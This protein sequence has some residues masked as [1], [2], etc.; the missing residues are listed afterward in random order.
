MEWVATK[1]KVRGE[2]RKDSTITVTVFLFVH[3]V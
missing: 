2:R 3:N 1:E